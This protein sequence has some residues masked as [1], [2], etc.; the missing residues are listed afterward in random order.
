MIPHHVAIIMDGNRRW[1]KQRHLEVLRGHAKGSDNLREIARACYDNE[2]S[3]LTCFA[4]SSENWRRSS[5][6]VDGLIRLMKQFLKQDVPQLK[7][8]NVKLRIIGD[9]SPFDDELQSLFEKAIKETSA[10]TGLNLSIAVNYGGQQDMLSAI[11]KLQE[12]RHENL[13]LDDVKSATQTS[14]LPKVDLLIR[15]GGERR[16]SN[17]M[18][19][20]CAYAELYFSDK[21]WPD[22]N[23]LDLVQALT[24]FERRDRRFG[25]DSTEQ[26][27]KLVLSK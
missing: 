3:F 2:V 16:I 23:E 13:T 17:F 24:D 26:R 4:F 10:N 1:A 14:A 21:F 22:F 6:E 11:Q 25:G 7:K 5:F 20:D 8:D 9:L 12:Q 27:A 18:L 15:T 19:W